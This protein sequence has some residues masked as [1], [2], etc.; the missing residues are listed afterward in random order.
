MKKYWI[1]TG[2]AFLGIKK[3]RIR[4]VPSFFGMEKYRIATVFFIFHNEKPRCHASTIKS[5]QKPPC[6]HLIFL[7]KQP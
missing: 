6:F 3:H 2:L 7:R 1:R 5:S 4:T